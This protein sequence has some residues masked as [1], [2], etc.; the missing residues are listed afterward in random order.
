M[1]AQYIITHNQFGRMEVPFGFLKWGD[2]IN[3][4]ITVGVECVLMYRP[5]IS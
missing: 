5:R 1:S 4:A 2:K 3:T